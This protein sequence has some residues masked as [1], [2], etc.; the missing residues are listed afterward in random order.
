M[1]IRSRLIL[2]N[3]LMILAPV[4]C[5]A[6]VVV[7]GS[8]YLDS[9]YIYT[10][11]EFFSDEN[12]VVSAKSTIYAYQKELWSTN[13]QELEDLQEESDVQESSAKEPME[14]SDMG[15]AKS[16][17]NQNA[18][19][20]KLG[21]SLEEMGYHFAVFMDGDCQYSNMSAA[22][23]DVV[24]GSLAATLASAGN[25]TVSDR[26]NSVIKSTFEK[27]GVVCE[28]VA[29][30]RGNKG[31][32]ATTV[33][34]LRDTLLL[35]VKIMLSVVAA[36]VF[37]A[38]M[39]LSGWISRSILQ[40]LERLKNGTARI[41]DG[42]LDGSILPVGGIKGRNEIDLACEDFEKMREYL[43]ETARERAENEERRREMISGIS[44]DLRTPLAAIEGYIEGL[45][46]GIAETEEKRNRYLEAA[47]V[48]S[49]DLERLVDRLSLY[50]RY[51]QKAAI[52]DWEEIE[53]EGFLEN[54]VKKYRPESESGVFT[55][56]VEKMA[57]QGVRVR[58]DKKELERVFDNLLS[59]SRKYGN[60]AECQV[61]VTGK[62]CGSMIQINVG[63]NGPGVE[64]P[65]LERIFDVF[66]RTDS[67][68]SCPGNGSGLGLAIVRDIVEAHKGYVKAENSGSGLDICI[69]L[70]IVS[71]NGLREQ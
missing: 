26:E 40:P 59:N 54:W 11:N 8:G 15:K 65:Q 21:V 64:E 1:K 6:A 61:E 45:R 28:I 41:M 30:N 34:E 2:A 57:F 16:E 50:N 39:V 9:R 49:K 23:S 46:T 32:G 7:M 66:Y 31:N 68:R 58:A 37:F 24:E 70:P 44:H 3:I 5:G 52:Y 17:L 25:V 48:R 55:I 29:I 51:Q 18:R 62:V 27:D 60:Q 53:L 33:D 13:W 43:R 10:M 47:Y 38:D 63:D 36:A 20:T 14:L 4:L 19:M 67:A 35:L 69:S 42:D 12:G 71:M 22:D 56:L